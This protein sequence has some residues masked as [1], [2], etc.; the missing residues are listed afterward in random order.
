MQYPSFQEGA[1]RLKIRVFDNARSVAELER[2][3]NEFTAGVHVVDVQYVTGIFPNEDEQNRGE[4]WYSLAV[5]YQ[6]ERTP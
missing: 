2:K 4:P 3:F 1:C 6:E 5:V